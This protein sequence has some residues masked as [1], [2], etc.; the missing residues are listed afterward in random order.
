[1]TKPPRSFCILTASVTAILLPSLA[2]AQTSAKKV[3]VDDK[4]APATISAE[5]MTGRPDRDIN[6]ENDV[7]ITRGQTTVNSDR[8]VF[9]QEENAIDASGNV[10]VKR[11]GDQFTG[12]A[13]ELNLDSGVGFMSHPTYKLEINN[14]QGRADRID[15]ESE[16]RAT[17][18]DGT[19]STCEG[20]DPDWY[21]KTGKLHLD[22]GR[23]LGT[24]SKTVIYFKGVPILGTPAMSF[25]LTGERKSGVLPPTLGITSK[26]GVEFSL[27]YYFNIAPNRDLTLYPKLISKR[28]LQLG[29]NGRYL[30]ESYAGETN[31]E[32]LY[33]DRQT[34]TNR[35]AYSSTHTQTL[36]PGLLFGWNLNGASDNDYPNDF[37]SSI[38]ASSARLLPRETSLSYTGDSWKASAHVARYQVL[39]DIAVPIARPYDRVPQLMF[40]TGQPDLNGF[41]WALDSEATR[42]SLSDQELAGRDRGD[43]VIV[44]P[45][46]S[47]PF[48]RPGYFL[49]PKLSLNATTYRLENPVT[50]PTSLNRSLPTFSLDSGL[51]FERD[52][53]FLGQAMTQTLEPRLFYVNTPFRDQNRFPVFDTADAGFGFAQLFSENRFSGGDRIGDANQI[54]TGLVSRFLE[55]SGAERMKFAI[56]QRVNFAD[57]RVVLNPAVT[58]SN[59]SRSDVLMAATGRLSSS[60]AVDSSA[61]Y[62]ESNHRMTAANLGVQWQPGPKRVLNAEYRYLR[63][64]LDIF[65]Q[66]LDQV[67]L[68][69]QWPLSQRWYGVGR[70]S[71]AIP[72]HKTAESLFG[73]EYNA[74]CWVFRVVAQRFPRL[75]RSR[76]AR[77][78]YSW[79]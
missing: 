76:P 2:F 3:R 21:L 15:F 48:I 29:A 17:V 26:G 1:M 64:T 77:C 66:S 72:E 10:R 59:S 16:D 47:Y 36:A 20:P 70:I 22:M 58:N 31:I 19:Y 4:N 74:D 54:T 62:S 35:Y 71:Y 43:R 30:G 5:Q 63:D 69:G 65:G 12:D 7:E 61:Q 39:Q 28:G 49:T 25:P 34:K 18:V 57:Q 78:F 51:T 53:Q 75:P 38:T 50:G 6:L 27:P 67:N 73:L 23:E 9:H 42:F 40:H 46:I 45:Q 8:A 33:D 68:S 13:L 14:G 24:A 41:N 44:N 52:T 11:F 79:S 56:A 55:S 37:A 60:L 32:T